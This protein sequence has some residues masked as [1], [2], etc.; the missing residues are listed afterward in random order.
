MLPLTN[1]SMS[2]HFRN[3]AWL[4]MGNLSLHL[5]KGRPAVHLDHDLIV[6]HLAIP[7]PSNKLDELK[8][9]LTS[10]G[11]EMRQNLSVPNPSAEGAIGDEI[12]LDQVRRLLY[13][14]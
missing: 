8:E 6:G 11:I 1:D 4:H 10:A 5:I 2:N 3:E 14:L 13:Y 9:R 12:P 7:I